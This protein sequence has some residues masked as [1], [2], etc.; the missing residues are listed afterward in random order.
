VLDRLPSP[1]VDE[2]PCSV[3]IV[4]LG[5]LGDLTILRGA[6][7]R[8]LLAGVG[9]LI[10]NLSAV[11]DWEFAER[12]GKAALNNIARMLALAGPRQTMAHPH[13]RID[14]PEFLQLVIEG[15]V[16]SGL[17]MEVSGSSRPC[18]GA[19]HLI[20]HALDASETGSALHGEQVGIATIFCLT[21]HG[22]DVAPIRRFAEKIGMK[23]T[24]E[25]VSISRDE[26]IKSV[27]DGPNMRIGRWTI[28]NAVNDRAVIEDA[29]DACFGTISTGRSA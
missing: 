11:A 9:D 29:Y 16:L 3:L 4:P 24:P 20:S 28:L 8:L 17:A 22:I 25:S 7:K 2:A 15:L 10:S 26:F 13:P 14:D 6:P 12:N 27:E 21:L 19:E 23:I 18:S 5:V 1:L